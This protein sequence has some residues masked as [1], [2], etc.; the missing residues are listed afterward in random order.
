LSVGFHGFHGVSKRASFAD[1]EK[2]NKAIAATKVGT[3]LPGL[4][5]GL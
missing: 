3:S 4:I 2:Y 1:A 5:H